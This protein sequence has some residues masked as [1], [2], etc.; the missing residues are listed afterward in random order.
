MDEH[1][2]WLEANFGARQLSN[3]SVD[4]IRHFFDNELKERSELQKKRAKLRLA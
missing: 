3:I 1:L 2:R 4:K